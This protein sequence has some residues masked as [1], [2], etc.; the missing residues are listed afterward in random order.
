MTAVP[1]DLAELVVQGLDRIGGVDHPAQHGRKLQERD[2]PGLGVLEH[3]DRVGVPLP[4]FGGGELGQRGFGGV[5]S[6]RFAVLVVHESRCC[7]DQLDHT[8]LDHRLG[9]CLSR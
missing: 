2:E 4:E 7:P 3:P 1:D 5:G 8:G 6:D 9:P